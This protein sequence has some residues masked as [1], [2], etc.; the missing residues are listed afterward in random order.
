MD[1]QYL[2]E[3]IPCDKY[4]L[5]TRKELEGLSRDQA[6]LIKQMQ[7]ALKEAHK[8]ILSDQQKSFFLGEQ[9]YN[10]KNKLFGKSSEK[11]SLDKGRKKEKKKAKKRVRLPSER[12][13]NLD[14]VE[15]EVKAD[16]SLDCPSCTEQMQESGLFETS[17]YLTFIPRKYYV[18]R[19]KRAKYRCKCCQEALV[20]TPA[21]PR[22]VPGGVYSDE[23]II[24]VAMSK[25]LDLIPVERY[26]QIAAR[27]GLKDLPPNSLIN[28]THKL[29]TML[30]GC[31][32]LIKKE[33]FEDEVIHADET[34]H[35][36]LE[37]DKKSSWYMWGFST[38]KGSYFELH[39]TRSGDVA[40]NLLKDSSCKYLV[41]D[42]FSG[43]AKAVSETNKE[44]EVKIKHLYCNA[45]ARRKFKD[46][47]KNFDES[48]FFLKLYRKIYRLEDKELKTTLTPKERRKYQRLYMRV[49]ERRTLK[50]MNLYSKH[51]SI[52]KAVNYF[53]NNF[54]DLLRF[55]TDAVLPI[56]N[57]AQEREMRSPVVGRKTWY[58]THSKQGAKTTG[59]MFT[60]VQSC[61]IN[62]LNPREFITQLVRDLHEGRP[63]YTPNQY[64]LIKET[65]A[66]QDVN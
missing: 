65:E 11:S 31:Y 22:I 55:T 14:I 59:I 17:E 36:M 60:I 33:V 57:N 38:T 29:A 50:M 46:A 43:Y 63:A 13:G 56:D 7:A 21:I 27:E 26:S 15:K 49:M 54:D 41:S 16:K 64:R 66:S 34:P 19:E 48:E 47:K 23:M 5:L 44:R 10:I 30:L 40:S 20:T 9:L 52:A 42:V 25:Y 45:H 32:K 4:N 61:K 3:P 51:S 28:V 39:D 58:G 1:Q 35:R 18:V 8:K 37:G 53:L 24:D 12:Y 6:D 62:K 2:F